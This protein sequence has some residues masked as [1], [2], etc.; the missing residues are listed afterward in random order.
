MR[1]ELALKKSSIHYKAANY[2]AYIDISE[3]C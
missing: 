1:I 2:S 3:V